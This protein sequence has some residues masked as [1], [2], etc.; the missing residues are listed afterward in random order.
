MSPAR[1]RSTAA[2]CRAQARCS[3]RPSRR[4]G[5]PLRPGTAAF[6]PDG[7]YAA[8]TFEKGDGLIPGTYAVSMHCWKVAA[9]REDRSD[10]ESFIPQKYMDAQQSGLELTVQ[11]GTGSVTR[12]LELRSE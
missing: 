5:P 2:P 1:S 12:D 10:A 7:N 6:G 3:S 4:P 11:G 9:T 8:G